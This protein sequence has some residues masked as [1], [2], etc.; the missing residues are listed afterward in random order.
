MLDSD[1]N[2]KAFGR[3]IFVWI[4]ITICRR[5]DKDFNMPSPPIKTRATG[6]RGFVI[7]FPEYLI[8]KIHDN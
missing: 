8:P 7:Q 1:K 4:T 3:F 5:Y 6:T 2:N